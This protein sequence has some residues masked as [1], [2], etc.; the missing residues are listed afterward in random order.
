MACLP[1]V[2][3][4]DLGSAQLSSGAGR[5]ERREMRGMQLQIAGYIL[6]VSATCLP[7]PPATY[8]PP[9][10]SARVGSYRWR[11]SV[12]V[13]VTVD[14][15]V[16]LLASCSTCPVEGDCEIVP[17]V[18]SGACYC[19]PCSRRALPCPAL[20]IDVQLFTYLAACLFCPRVVSFRQPFDS[21]LVHGRLASGYGNTYM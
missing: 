10:C 4:P 2:C 5:L 16:V 12:C 7:R 1:A 11:T 9:V 21:S 6:G 3:L 19:W 14:A 15:G 13:C 20:A 17:F 18:S 8:V